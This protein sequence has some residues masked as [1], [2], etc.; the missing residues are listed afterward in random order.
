VCDSPRKRIA[1][2]RAPCRVSQ[3]SFDKKEMAASRS[4]KKAEALAK[5]KAQAQASS[6][7]SSGK[8]K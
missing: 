4:Q 5:A 8:K 6:S 2:T 3:P 1:L 7:A